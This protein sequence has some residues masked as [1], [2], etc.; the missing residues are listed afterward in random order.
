MK[1]ENKGG[2]SERER[3]RGR[4]K[5][6]GSTLDGQPTSLAQILQNKMGLV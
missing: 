4:E 1:W 3:K 6:R 2:E 5:E